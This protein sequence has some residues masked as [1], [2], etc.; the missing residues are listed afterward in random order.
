MVTFVMR[1]QP[2]DDHPKE[3]DFPHD[4]GDSSP[5]IFLETKGIVI[6]H[7]DG[8]V[9]HV[10]GCRVES[11]DAGH[12]DRSRPPARKHEW[13]GGKRI[14]KC[15]ERNECEQ[16]PPRHRDEFLMLF[17]LFVRALFEEIFLAGK[18]PVVR[19]MMSLKEVLQ[20]P[21]FPMQDPPMEGPF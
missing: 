21:P 19:D 1:V 3:R 13:Y 16:T 11:T 6:I 14:R 8:L 7:M 9:D 4:F 5:H 15:A 20:E 17:E 10:V 18:V 2:I 12:H